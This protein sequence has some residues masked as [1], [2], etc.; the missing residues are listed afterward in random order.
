MDHL[1]TQRSTLNQPPPRT[2]L[3]GR[4]TYEP[5]KGVRWIN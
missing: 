1:I 5:P 3:A 2:G 4:F